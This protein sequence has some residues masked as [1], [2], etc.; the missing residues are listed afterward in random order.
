[1]ADVVFQS[2]LHLEMFWNNIFLKKIILILA[3]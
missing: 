1:M 2:A 3:Y